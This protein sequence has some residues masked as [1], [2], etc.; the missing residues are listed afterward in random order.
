[1]AESPLILII[2]SIYLLLLYFAIGG[3][4]YITL[5][6]QWA[7][8]KNKTDY[9]SYIVRSYFFFC[10]VSL[11]AGLFTVGLLVAGRAGWLSETTIFVSDFFQRPTVLILLPLQ[12]I[13]AIIN[14]R[15]WLRLPIKKHSPWDGIYFLISLLL[16]FLIN[17]GTVLP[18]LAVHVSCCLI[19][20]GLW[21]A[22]TAAKEK[23]IELKIEL[24]RRTGWLVL[25]LLFVA[26][27]CQ[28]W[29]YATLA[30]PSVPWQISIF[31]SCL[32]FPLILLGMVFFPRHA[33]YI[34]TG[35]LLALASA[36]TVSFEW[37]Y[38]TR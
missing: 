26:I 20:A 23:R 32:L 33:G 9:L 27:A 3:G 12:V 5:L 15:Q 11:A 19:V 31:I 36:A 1:M 34:S 6:E 35:I 8:S 30:E 25:V 37:G 16:L 38:L 2:L 14:Y 7:R 18:L 24:T 22:L 13:A 4:I 28:L 29:N 10:C 21:V 17:K